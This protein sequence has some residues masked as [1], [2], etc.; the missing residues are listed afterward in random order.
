MHICSWTYYVLS[1]HV[2]CAWVQIFA[3]LVETFVERCL[4]RLDNNL[5]MVSHVSVEEGSSSTLK[6]IKNG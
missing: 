4:V 2:F 3:R 1:L 5:I 6:T